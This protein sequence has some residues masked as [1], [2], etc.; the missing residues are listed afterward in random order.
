MTWRMGSPSIPSCI[1]ACTKAMIDKTC[2]LSTMGFLVRP[3]AKRA[4]R[5]GYI[6]RDWSISNDHKENK[7][8]H[9]EEEEEKKEEE[10][11]KK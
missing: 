5:I 9:K 6:N 3:L 2:S 1:G 7:E 8:E 11:E 4:H 10:K